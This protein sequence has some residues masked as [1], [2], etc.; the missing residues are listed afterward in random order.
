MRKSGLRRKRSTA[1]SRSDVSPFEETDR[2]VTR[3]NALIA[4]NRCYHPD[5]GRRSNDQESAPRDT[6]SVSSINTVVHRPIV[7]PYSGPG[8]RRR[9]TIRFVNG[10]PSTQRSAGGQAVERFSF[11]RGGRPLLD[12]SKNIENRPSSRSSNR[13]SFVTRCPTTSS[14][15]ERYLQDM[16]AQ[17]GSTLLC[18]PI[19]G[20]YYFTDNGP[21]RQADQPTRRAP[22]QRPYERYDENMAPAVTPEPHQTLKAPKS[23]SFL[24]ARLNQGG[25]SHGGSRQASN[26]LAIH[27]AK[28][29]FREQVREQERLSVRSSLFSHTLRKRRDTSAGFRQRSLRDTSG[30]GTN[31]SLDPVS[32]NTLPVPRG[33]G[34]RKKVRKVSSRLKLK[35]R[36]LFRRN[37]HEEEE[38]E[39][40]GA[41]AE[42]PQDHDLTP[43]PGNEFGTDD[44]TED[45]YTDMERTEP[46]VYT[47]G[48]VLVRR[49]SLHTAE[50]IQ[51]A[52]S[53]RASIVSADSD[54]QVDPDE[55]SR[56]TSWATSGVATVSSDKT[57]Q[58]L[59]IITE[60][61]PQAVSVY[62]E[63]VYSDD[64]QPLSVDGVD[65]K[66][67]AVGKTVAYSPATIT[68][69]FTF[70]DGPLN[71]LISQT[72]LDRAAFTDRIASE[73]SSV[74]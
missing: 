64:D 36:N 60:G 7:H 22:V 31:I 35:L 53:R 32:A 44:E 14:Y 38:A 43:A 25:L 66:D 40:V 50:S 26:D 72:E 23:M 73:A 46:E 27:M 47:T 11:D 49:P 18:Q 42:E 45:D 30:A 62:S 1:S 39:V 69:P 20:G 29:R 33:D 54:H 19:T 70:S 58:R 12:M 28:E 17:R 2:A 67:H 63:S 9:Q 15:T 59:S 56:V 6:H 4:A 52:R 34:F 13:G 68:G 57:C 51:R 37:K 74:D 48:T 24:K 16:V 10:N 3:Q 65:A 71:G 21:E 55:K 8:L 61:A 41:V 5:P